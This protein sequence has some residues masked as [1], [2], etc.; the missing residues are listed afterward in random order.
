MMRRALV[1]RKLQMH[2]DDAAGRRVAAPASLY[3]PAVA[4]QPFRILL[5]FSGNVPASRDV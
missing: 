5:P 4:E 3:P 2:L 1:L